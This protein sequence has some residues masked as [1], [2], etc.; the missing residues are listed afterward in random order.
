VSRREAWLS[1]GLVFFVALVVRA[2]AA[3]QI[4][5]PRPEDTA[6]YVGV[7]RNLL[8]GRGLT[9]DVVWSYAT[10]PLVL[11]RPAFE[12]WLPLPSFLMAIPM[13]L[14]GHT[15][16]AAQVASVLEGA[17]VAVLAWWLAAEVALERGLT[18]TRARWLALGAGLASAVYLPLVLA[19]AQPDSTMPFAI[20]VLLATLVARRILDGASIP[21]AATPL[22]R[23]RFSR[24]APR[25]G[26]PPAPERA[27]E[28]PRVVVERRQVRLLALL[29]V[30]LGLA[31]L[32]RNEAIWLA[33]AW[34][35]LAW[36]ATAGAGS[37]GLRGRAWLPLVAI[38]ALVSIVVYS[39]WAL[40]DWSVFGTPLPGQALSNAL[41]LKGDDIFAWAS[42]PTLDRYLAAGLPT[43]IGQR[44][45]AL[46]HN[47]GN[48][49]LLLGVPISAI[50][51][52]AL[53]WTARGRTLWLLVVFSVLSFLVT[54]LVFPVATLAGTFLHGA[55]AIQV[56]V[57]ISAVVALDALLER[58]RAAMS[59][60]NPVAWIGA[61]AAVAGSALLGISLLAQD[62][63]SARAT[64][65]TYAQLP[66]ALAAAGAPLPTDGSPVISDHPIWL[67]TEDGVRAIS[68]PD[69]FPA[70]VLDLANRFGVTMLIVDGRNGGQWPEILD[71]EEPGA[72]CFQLVPLQVSDE[73]P[74][75]NV[76][77]FR[78]ICSGPA[79]QGTP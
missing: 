51:L 42:P 5:F 45:E 8:E 60:T 38:P 57:V 19:S 32:A 49:L 75:G 76:V 68:L 18:A 71:Q 69:E 11:P 31:A 63:R 6:Y 26:S 10:P 30:L 43:L 56:L 37:L 54:T 61:T 2:W 59:W 52:L 41:F 67:A 78:I 21:I 28:A 17:A 58:L 65:E 29:G 72:E 53:P 64:G 74:L 7:A 66:A 3:S 15:F 48:D 23:F 50:G 70:D 9:I 4:T 47:L 33:L 34:A 25:R 73:G 16:A 79:V 40:R 44:I 12:I 13:A 14:F 1:A 35:V 39:P 27:P 24:R 77:V 22:P 62:G 55:G 46:V 20:L 36:R